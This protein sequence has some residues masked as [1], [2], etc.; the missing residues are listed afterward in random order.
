MQGKENVASSSR[1]A[2]KD[3]DLVT[4]CSMLLLVG[5]ATDEDFK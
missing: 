4:V 1:S 2:I 3:L 5:T